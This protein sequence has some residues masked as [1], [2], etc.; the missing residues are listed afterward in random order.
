M[1]RSVDA[2]A[3][4]ADVLR[5]PT[6]RAAKDDTVGLDT[7]ADDLAATVFALRRDCVYRA[8]EAVERVGLPADQH[9][10]RLVVVVSTHSQ[11]GIASVLL[12]ALP[13]SMGLHAA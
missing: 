3:N 11:T 6:M 10:E 8:F 13:P 7:V 4:A 9:G 5:R 1:Q 2:I 12:A